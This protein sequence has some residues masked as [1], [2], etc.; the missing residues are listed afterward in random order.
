[1]VWHTTKLNFVHSNTTLSRVVPINNNILQV[2]AVE[3]EYLNKEF[4]QDMDDCA[5]RRCNI[6]Q[7]RNIKESER[8]T[9]K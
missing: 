4:V 1:M 3:K 6:K 7:Q 5:T 9:M 2:D 8:C